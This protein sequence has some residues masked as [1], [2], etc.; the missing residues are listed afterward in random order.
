M[1]DLSS[2][3]LTTNPIGAGL[4]KESLSSVE[5]ELTTRLVYF[6]MLNL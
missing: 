2:A 5:L 6:M 1:L 3:G 4:R